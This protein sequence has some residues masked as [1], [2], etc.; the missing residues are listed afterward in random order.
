MYSSISRGTLQNHRVPW[1]PWLGNTA[2][3]KRRKTASNKPRRVPSNHLQLFND[4]WYD[5][6]GLRQNC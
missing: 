3:G 6:S 5:C 4:E 2:P 1:K